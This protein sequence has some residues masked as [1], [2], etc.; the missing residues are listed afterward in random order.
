MINNITTIVIR[1]FESCTLEPAF[2]LL[3]LFSGVILR[4]VNYVHLNL[5]FSIIKQINQSFVNQKLPN[6]SKYLK[7]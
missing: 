1:I 3:R 6:D 2:R 7:L 4:S 5:G